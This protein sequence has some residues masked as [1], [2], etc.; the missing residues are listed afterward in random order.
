[1]TL[2]EQMLNERIFVSPWEVSQ[3]L[4]VSRQH[5][6]NLV[7]KERLAGTRERPVRITT[8]SLRRYIE[9][10]VKESPFLSTV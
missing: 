10:C 9:T 3:M 6:Y 1:M 5:V 4:G 7:N 8:K 2:Q